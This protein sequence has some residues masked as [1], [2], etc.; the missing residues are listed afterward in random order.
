[1]YPNIY[2]LS[3]N[4]HPHHLYLIFHYNLFEFMSRSIYHHRFHLTT[5]LALNQ[6][7][8][9]YQNSNPSLRIV[10]LFYCFHWVYSRYYLSLYAY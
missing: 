1:M 3:K 5:T 10:H 9:Q 7:S 2:Q 8:Q 4:L 6:H